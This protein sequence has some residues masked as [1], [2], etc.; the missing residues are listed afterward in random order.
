VLALENKTAIA[1]PAAVERNALIFGAARIL[2]RNYG[3]AA[4]FFSEHAAAG[5]EKRSPCL[6]WLN[7]YH[8]YALLLDGQYASAAESFK[9]LA[10]SCPDRL[11]AG[12]AAYFLAE[13]LMKALPGQVYDLSGAANEGRERVRASLPKRAAWDRELAKIETEVHGV[14]LSRY[15]GNAAVWLYGGA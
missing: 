5:K 2:S 13:H 3:A 14:L 8:A 11:A 15:M 12:L 6:P 4:R 9:V 7:L 1:K 10:R